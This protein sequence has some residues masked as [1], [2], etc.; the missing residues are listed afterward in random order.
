MKLFDDFEAVKFPEENLIFITNGGY[1][2]YIYNPKYNC[3][4]KYKD[5]GNLE[6]TVRKYQDIT[7]KEL[8]KALGGI[9]PQKETDFM[10]CCHPSQLWPRNMFNLLKEDYSSYMADDDIRDFIQEFLYKSNIPY[11]SYL[12]LKELLDNAIT[13]KQNNEQVLIEI[14]E[15][16]FA[17]IGRDILKKEIEIIDGHDSSSYFWIKPVRVIDFSDTNSIDNVTEMKTVEISI[18]EDD[19]N[20]F[21]TPFLYKY[22]DNE[23]KVNKKRVDNCSD[24]D[25]VSYVSGFEWYL[26]H[27]FYTYH[28]VE[29]MLDDIR[30]TIDALSLRRENEYTT[31][32]REKRGWATYQLCYVK[33]WTEEQIK[34][35]ND[36][37]PKEDDTEVDLIIDFYERFIYRMEYMIRIGKEKGY[38]LISFMGP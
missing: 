34:E 32:L 38:N 4:E 21:L 5:A 1:L 2:Y 3:W 19:V 24:I 7:Q 10:R 31:K 17:I 9:L 22:F 36:N 14:K 16:S 15:L 27:N 8:E 13:L 11:K 35:Y 20:Q 12:K 28:A 30:D 6:L 26:T 18:E 29:Q 37:R 23:L 25:N 33:D